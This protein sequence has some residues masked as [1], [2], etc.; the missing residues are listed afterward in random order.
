[1][2]SEVILIYGPC[3][4]V[5]TFLNQKFETHP[6]I[7]IIILTTN[8]TTIDELP[9]PPRGKH[10]WPWTDVPKTDSPKLNEVEAPKVS[11]VTPSYNQGEYLEESIRSVLLQNYP[12]IEY[13]II[14]GGSSDSTL[15]IVE[16]YYKWIT[17]F[18]SE[19]DSGQSDAINK[20]FARCTGKIFNWLCSDDYLLPG[21]LTRVASVLDMKQPSWMIAGATRRDDAV[22]DVRKGRIPTTVDLNTFLFWR[23]RGIAQPSIFWNDLIF[24]PERM[25]DPNLHYC[26]DVDLWFRFLKIAKPIIDHHYISCRR[27]HALA[28]TTPISDSYDSFNRELAQWMLNKIYRSNDSALQKDILK[29]MI[30]MQTE[31]GGLHKLIHHPVFGRLLRVWKKLVNNNIIQ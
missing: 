30:D 13:I 9:N 6:S 19:Q 3:R 14:D 23:S 25:V 27:I 20:G 15:E 12:K 29:G 26:M 21:S 7:T 8:H 24:D 1:M 5:Y 22:A 17:L 16:K 4:C 18:V 31:I 10:G 2:L 11:I 28:K